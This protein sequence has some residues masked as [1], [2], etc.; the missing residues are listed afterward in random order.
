MKSQVNLRKLLT[1]A[2]A[3]AAFAS[4]GVSALGQCAMCKVSAQASSS[5]S[6]NP[7]AVADA[8]NLAVLVLLIP[9]VLIF[10]ALFLVLVRYRRSAGEE[11]S[12]RLLSPR[13]AF[14]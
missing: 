9:P 4:Q 10:A 11:A 14:D 13:G 7:Q 2:C 12:N 8:F 5:A 1:A 6:A 3:L